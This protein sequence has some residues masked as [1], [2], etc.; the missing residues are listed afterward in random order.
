MVV[1]VGFPHSPCPPRATRFLLSVRSD[2]FESSSD[3][4]LEGCPRARARAR[5]P[6]D[7]PR[8]DASGKETRGKESLSPI[9]ALVVAAFAVERRRVAG[10]AR[11]QRSDGPRAREPT[12][13]TARD[14]ATGIR[15]AMGI[16]TRETRRW[17][18]DAN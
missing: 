10:I 7:D 3:D 5:A 16:R 11:R 13:W 18:R 8:R 1:V 14:D 12:N 15:D 17:M 6:L 2:A 9:P 4:R